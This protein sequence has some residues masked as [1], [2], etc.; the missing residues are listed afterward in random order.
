MKDILIPFSKKIGHSTTESTIADLAKQARN[1]WQQH[2][3]SSLEL[4]GPTQ[5][6]PPTK[7]K[8]KIKKEK[9]EKSKPKKKPKIVL[10]DESDFLD[11]EQEEDD[12]DLSNPNQPYSPTMPFRNKKMSIQELD[13]VDE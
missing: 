1:V 10:S 13:E 2:I 8:R 6:P 4:I 7:L 11:N 12:D 3:D 9:G 5:E